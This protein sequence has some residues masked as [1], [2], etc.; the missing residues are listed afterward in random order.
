MEEEK[1]EEYWSRF[2]DTYD[3]NQEHVVGKEF[4]DEIIEELNDLRD[5]G[6]VIEFGCGTGLFT[7]TLAQ[8]A[9]QM[10]ASDLSH[11][12]LERAKLR[13]NKNPK[14]TV[15]KED[16]MHTSFASRTFDSVFMANLIHVVEYPL[17]ALQES[18]RILKDGGVLIIVTYTNY[19]MKLFEKIKLGIRFLIVWGRPPRH[20]HTFS[21]ENLASLVEDAGFIVERSKLIGT[22]TKAIYLLGKKK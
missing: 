14:I 11:E 18:H 8:N 2:A 6:D 10:T 4:L 20:V 1:T 17:R 16:C 21:P 9:N 7:E 22:K 3:K 15:Q 5:L 19:G 13:L 12:L